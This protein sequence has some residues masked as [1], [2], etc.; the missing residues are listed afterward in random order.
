NT[1]STATSDLLATFTLEWQHGFL[2][3]FDYLMLLNS[4]SGRS[5]NDLTQ[6]PVY[7]WILSDYDSDEL[8]LYNV[9]CFRDLS[10]PMGALDETRAYIHRQKYRETEALWKD[11]E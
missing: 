2:S 7:P 3:N 5:F 9:Q 1:L 8:D 6:Y 10:K 4:F 11:E